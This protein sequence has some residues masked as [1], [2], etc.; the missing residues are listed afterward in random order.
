NPSVATIGSST[1]VVTSVGTGTTVISYNTGSSC[2]S[3]VIVTVNEA[4]SAISGATGICS[5]STTTLSNSISGG[6]WSSGNTS[7][8]TV[9]SSTGVV[10]GIA[11]GTATIMY[12]IGSCSVTTVV[13]VTAAP[14]AIA[15]TLSV[16]EGSSTTLSNTTGGG[17]WSSGDPSVAS[18]TASTG[19]ATGVAAGTAA[20]TYTIGTCSVT[21]V[22]TVNAAS[23]A[24]SGGTTLFPSLTTVL[25]AS[26]P[27]GAW[28]S[29]NVSIATV[30]SS[31]GIVTA[32]AAG[33]ATITYSLG[34][35]LSVTTEVTVLSEP[36][37]I[38]GGLGLEVG[39]GDTLSNAVEGGIWSSSNTAVATIG[40]VSGILT[41]VGVGTT[42]ISYMVGGTYLA[43]VVVTVTS[44][45]TSSSCPGGWTT[46]SGI[47]FINHVG[48]EQDA[49]MVLDAC[50]TPYVLSS[51]SSSR[52]YLSKY[53]GR[54]FISMGGAV[55][56][57]GVV[58]KAMS[59][60]A[61]GVAY[62]VYSDA[63]NSNKATVKRNNAGI[64]ETVGIAG[65]SSGAI[66]NPAIGIN[67]DGE[68]YVAFSN[69]LGASYITVMKYNGTSWEAVGDMSYYSVYINSIDIQ[70]DSAGTPYVY[71]P[72]FM[73]ILQYDGMYWN[74]I[75]DEVFLYVPPS[76]FVVAPSGEIFVS[77]PPL[78]EGSATIMRYDGT[79]WSTLSSCL[80]PPAHTLAGCKLALDKE[81]Q[82]WLANLVSN[83]GGEMTYSV[84]R[85][86][87]ADWVPVNETPLPVHPLL[88][89]YLN[90]QLRVDTGGLAYLRVISADGLTVVRLKNGQWDYLNSGVDAIE[91]DGNNLVMAVNGG[92]IPYVAYVDDFS[93][94]TVKKFN[95]SLWEPVGPVSS[96]GH[97]EIDS[98]VSFPSIATESS[99]IIY[100]AYQK[101]AGGLGVKKFDGTE[102]TTVGSDFSGSRPCI[103]VD[104]LGV[105]YVCCSA[106]TAGVKVMRYD[107]SAWVQIGSVMTDL[108]A[109]RT[110]SGGFAIAGARFAISGTTPYVFA[111]DVDS[112]YRGTVKKFDGSD[113]VD[114]GS[115][116]ITE[117][118]V[119]DFG[120]A[121]ATDGTPFIVYATS[122]T[123]Y[124]V[125]V[126]KFNGTSWTNVGG[127]VGASSENTRTSIAMSGNVPV[128]VFADSD[129]GD[130]LTAR[131]FDGGSW[132]D[133][134]DVGFSS[135][136]P[137]S[138]GT[139]YAPSVS[140]YNDNV[141]VS[142][143][144][145]TPYDLIVMKY[146]T[147]TET[148]FEHSLCVGNSVSLISNQAGEW[149]SSNPS[150]A[151]INC[152][153]ILTG[154]SAGT[155]T[156]TFTH[157]S[158]YSTSVVTVNASPSAGVITGSSIVAPSSSVSLSASISG[159][160]WS[161]SDTATATIT[162]G[163]L[164]SGVLTGIVT[165]SYT[166]TSGSCSSYALHSLVV[167]SARPGNT[168]VKMLDE[169]L[170]FSVYPNPTSGGFNIQSDA[171]G[172]LTVFSIDGRVVVESKLDAGNTA[173]YMPLGSA[174]GVYVLRFA[175]DDG[176]VKTSKLIYNH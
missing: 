44:L 53:N 22:L 48:Y 145:G 13:T 153:G 17:V 129:H 74:E 130:T 138:E 75:Y 6:A 18:I 52:S 163:G 118:F 55:D 42:T 49:Q 80:L 5:G 1:G 56:T 166:V 29:S 35:C 113:W 14:S 50:G 47:P 21:T 115:P 122:T 43:T 67:A 16:C 149:S 137:S 97:M 158:C 136:P 87:G 32:V 171:T 40:S 152:A 36:A 34:S 147:S 159:G 7:V 68:P 99:G 164:A 114:V 91:V 102:W 108:V 104:S 107:G 101:S 63:L 60:N 148:S 174:T 54:E 73:S 86:S 132:I 70:F 78:G 76:Q 144:N 173:L 89:S 82:P 168:S 134:G 121:S 139:E 45:T 161:S 156:I 157:D 84:S 112:S 143:L 72:G 77:I 167:A 160:V 64:W 117:G 131:R 31:T 2:N 142:Y 116:G 27:G 124:S 41:A 94:L 151:S 100:V 46:L 66:Y 33:S 28:S 81:G 95:G 126:K 12:A 20:I 127:S 58:G 96:D 150:V 169:A 65:F 106:D 62:V 39:D 128:V 172:R 71:S 165:I 135:M 9:N 37:P 123:G 26:V 30:G 141:Y 146:G 155:A 11:A 140:V 105:P 79:S 85:Y 119:E 69:S 23:A 61:D 15:G 10:S 57:P 109:V 19:V 59:V 176:T 170:L 88:S 98:M 133:V 38:I 8:A 111:Q 25:S 154:I 24:I 93:Y 90:D 92:G 51:S 83:T 103:K 3:A 120:I 125:S 110:I 175:G 162:S 4:P